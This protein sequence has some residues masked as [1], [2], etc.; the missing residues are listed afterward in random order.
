MTGPDSSTTLSLFESIADVVNRESR[1]VLV[2]LSSAQSSNLKTA[3]NYINQRAT[4]QD[5]DSDDNTLFNESRVSE[6]TRN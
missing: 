6:C 3:L 1:T 2:T 4:S 5:L